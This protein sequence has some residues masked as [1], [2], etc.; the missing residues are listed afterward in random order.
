ML[1]SESDENLSTAQILE[2]SAPQTNVAHG[3]NAET[4]D[5]LQSNVIDSTI[6][7]QP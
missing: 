2:T 6:P 1:D 7:A 3:D 4:D 5:L